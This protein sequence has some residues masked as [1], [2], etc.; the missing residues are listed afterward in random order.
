MT[1]G[2]MVGWH[3]WLNGHEFEQTLEVVKGR[4]AGRAAVH[5]V[6]KSRTSPSNWTIIAEGALLCI[7]P[8]SKTPSASRTETVRFA[9]IFLSSAFTVTC[10]GLCS[11][12]STPMVTFPPGLMIPGT[13]T[14]NLGLKSSQQQEKNEVA[15][16]YI[17]ILLRFSNFIDGEIDSL[18]SV[19]CNCFNECGPTAPF[20]NCIE[21]L[22]KENHSPKSIFVLFYWEKTDIQHCTSLKCTDNDLTYT[23]YKMIITI[24]LVNIHHLT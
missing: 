14:R 3:H 5:G 19:N 18:Y 21:R 6:A 2:E 24:N 16:P 15:Y 8:F 9:A 11:R 17:F 22:L 23:C 13:V 7:L 12:S 20:I 4:E 10:E 1:E